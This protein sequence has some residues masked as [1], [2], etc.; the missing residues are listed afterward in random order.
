MGIKGIQR[1]IIWTVQIVSMWQ[2]LTTRTA[3]LNFNVSYKTVK[4]SS[5]FVKKLSS[6]LRL[7]HKY[8]DVNN[9]NEWL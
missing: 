3:Y 4:S 5:L 9:T 7:Y 6:N 8:W 1:E 2:G